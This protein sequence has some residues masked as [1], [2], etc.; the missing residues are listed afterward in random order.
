MAHDL[1][2]VAAGVSSPTDLFSTRR[3][4][5]SSHSPGFVALFDSLAPG[6]PSA[7]QIRAIFGAPSH[8]SMGD[9]ARMGPVAPGWSRIDG[10]AGGSARFL[11]QFAGAARR[12]A[13]TVGDRVFA[14][15]DGDHAVRYHQITWFAVDSRARRT[16][17][18]HFEA[19]L[20]R[21]C[22]RRLSAAR[23]RTRHCPVP[24]HVHHRDRRG[25][26]PSAIS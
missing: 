8:T 3:C 11:L 18:R 10:R 5:G 12:K 19:L 15:V 20:Y 4:T 22:R 26:K 13:P 21:R 6:A 17:P 1:A 23:R 16:R 7:V 14:S 25:E 2:G 24:P 9:A